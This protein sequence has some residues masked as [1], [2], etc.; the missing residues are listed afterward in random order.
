MFKTSL[1]VD[2]AVGYYRKKINPDTSNGK[3]Q[4]KEAIARFSFVKKY[5]VC[6]II[7][8]YEEKNVMN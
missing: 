2:L 1:L 7:H 6:Q 3:R 4:A 5:S 8:H